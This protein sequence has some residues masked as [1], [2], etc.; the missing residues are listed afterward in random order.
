MA[1]DQPYDRDGCFSGSALMLPDGRHLLMYT[2][3][4][5]EEQDGRMRGIQTQCVAIGD[6]VDYGKYE[7]NPVIS[8][9][10][11][12]KGSSKYDFRDPKL[13]QGKDGRYYA[14][15]VTNNPSK[16]GGQVLLFVSNDALKWRYET[17]IMSNN[18]RIGLMWE[19]P[20]FFEIDGKSVLM[21]SAMDMLPQDLKYY[22]L[23]F[24]V[25][26]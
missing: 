18:E 20:D 12:P 4:V 9:S 1:P 6:G 10:N 16:G 22:N 3:V 21:C 19:C 5:N 7:K 8:I 2:G 14:V 17:T 11:L 15:A 24:G 26:M 25:E 13:W 23:T